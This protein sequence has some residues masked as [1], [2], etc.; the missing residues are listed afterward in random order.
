LRNLCLACQSCALANLPSE[1][2]VARTLLAAVLLIADLA[3]ALR[4]PTTTHRMPPISMSG[5]GNARCALIDL[6][7]EEPKRVAQVLKQAWMEGGVKRGL[8]GAVFVREDEQKVQIACQGPVERLKSFADWIENSSMLVTNVDIMEA[9]A[10]TEPLTNKFPLAD[11]EAYSGGQ[12]GSFSGSL[13]DQLKTLAFDIK[14]KQ[15][16]THSS[17]EG[18]VM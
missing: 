7:A 16:K 17:D 9:G 1:A 12:P 15:G 13:A 5:A 6:A 3:A 11:A 2:M 18:L 10:F 14:A 4:V 8:V